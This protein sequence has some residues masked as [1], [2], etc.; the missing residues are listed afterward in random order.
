MR[1]QANESLL[2][3]LLFDFAL[4]TASFTVRL[5]SGVLAED[6]PIPKNNKF[7]LYVRL[8]IKDQTYKTPVSVDCNRKPSWGKEAVY[9]FFESRILDGDY[10][11][12]FE[13]WN[14]AT[15]IGDVLICSGQLDILS[16]FNKAR[17]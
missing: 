1:K 11:M 6:L 12:Q 8:F 9:N 13:V 17:A 5:E 7:D 4:E 16:V 3:Y 15:E 10:A 2:I 14:Y